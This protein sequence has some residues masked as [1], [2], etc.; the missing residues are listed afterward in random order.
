[1]TQITQRQLSIK[2][3]DL[4]QQ[5][6]PQIGGDWKDRKAQLAYAL[7]PHT[8]LPGI[9]D[10]EY[11]AISQGDSCPRW[12]SDTLCDLF[13]EIEGVVFEDDDQRAQIMRTIM[14]LRST[15]AS[16]EALYK[17]M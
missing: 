12:S 5:S 14:E 13:E 6:L 16:L 10:E 7:P 11:S 3:I 1:M 2:K 8:E 9:T 17:S 4:L 15:L